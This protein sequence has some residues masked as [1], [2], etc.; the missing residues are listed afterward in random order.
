[1]SKRGKEEKIGTRERLER[2]KRR[3][4]RR[5]EREMEVWDFLS[6]I[7]YIVW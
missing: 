4:K 3:S 2:N 5:R 1:M 6:I 7:S